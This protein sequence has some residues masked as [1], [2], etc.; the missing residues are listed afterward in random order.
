MAT[1]Q[2]PEIAGKEAEVA[3]DKVCSRV[4]EV[5]L[6]AAPSEAVEEFAAGALAPETFI[7]LASRYSKISSAKSWT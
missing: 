7:T 4:M 1:I 3:G 6:A 5:L 2:H